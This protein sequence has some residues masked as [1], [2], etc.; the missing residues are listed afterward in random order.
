MEG[1]YRAAVE[2]PQLPNSPTALIACNHRMTLEAIAKP[3]PTPVR[4]RL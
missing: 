2:V 1:G 3:R 4:A